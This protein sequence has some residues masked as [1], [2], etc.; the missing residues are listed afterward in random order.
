MRAQVRAPLEGVDV[1]VA[2]PERLLDL[3]KADALRPGEVD[4]VVLDEADCGR[5][6]VTPTPS[7]GS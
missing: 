7:K 3:V 5:P 4:L 1:L 2:P 6:R